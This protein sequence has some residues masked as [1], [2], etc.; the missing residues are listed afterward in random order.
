MGISSNA[1]RAGAAVLIGL[2]AP[3]RAWAQSTLVSVST[4][5]NFHTAGVLAT[6]SGDPQ[7]NAYC[8]LAY[9]R[10]ADA[11]FKPALSFP[12][13]DATHL[14]GSL[15]GL[16]PGTAYDVRVT[17]V[18]PDGV[19]G[20]ATQTTSVTTRADSF[21][22][23]SVQTLYV[24]TTGNDGNP[25][26]AALPLRTIGRAEA[27][28]APGT[29]VLIQPGV[30]REEVT[31]NVAG[32][33]AQP[34]VFRGNGLGAVLD[35]AD[36]AI[37]AG[38]PWTNE[39]GGVYARQTGFPTDHVVSERGRLYRYASPAALQA[40]GAGY[41]GGFHFDGTTLRVRFSDNTSPATHTMHVAR[42]EQGFHVTGGASFV[43]VENV[44]I[45]HYG[46]GGFGK[47][48]YLNRV[49]DSAVRACRIHEVESAGVWI[50]GGSRH[51]VEDNQIWDTNIFNWPWDLVKGSTAENNAVTFTDEAGQGHVLRRNT[52]Y[53][54]FNG[55]GPCGSVAIPQITT[56][57][58]VHHN[59]MS[60]HLDDALEPEG[61]CSNVRIF[62]N[63]IR[64]VHM[65]F[66][67]APANPGPTY[68]VRNVAYN[69]G[70]T[71]ASQVDGYLASA[72]KINSGFSEPVG[73]LF[74]LH[75]TF[76]TQAPLTSA[77]TLLNPGNSTSITARNN[78]FAGTDYALY[79][80]NPVALNWD[81]DDLHTTAASRLVRWHTGASYTTLG[82]FQS[83][84]GQEPTGLSAP[85]NL[86]NPAGG[87]Y[88]PATG[89][90]LINAGVP[91]GNINDDAIGAPDIGAIEVGAAPPPTTR[92]FTLPP[93]RLVDTRG[94][95]GPL[96]G[97]MIF[98]AAT[99][100]FPLTGTCGV[101]ATAK[102]LVLNATIVSPAA[103]GHIRLFP[104]NEAAPLAS[105]T[106]FVAGRNRAGIAIVRLATDGAGTV[107]LLNGSAG[108][109]HF[110]LD[111]TGY[112]E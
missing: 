52:T 88:Q 72:L 26:T 44:E 101:P 59:T 79:K 100:V 108:T 103:A 96:G 75:N 54:T 76:L 36:A 5:G 57:V 91:L 31:V 56:E 112:F 58:D 110:V 82:A 32:T 60:Q 3:A 23:P 51:V 102:A 16:T 8:T 11:A 38:V 41:P 97:P 64:D 109:L 37:A 25:G 61:H 27:L 49:N 30:Y 6:I 53:G 65:A 95:A 19:S 62:E 94:P 71:R 40:L 86:V 74:L 13:I 87:L 55:F 67:V 22:E 68:L 48:V 98:P 70:N 2:L 104:G 63:R 15:F 34:I 18:D 29:L 4:Y 66:A 46:S 24:A 39:G 28:A 107:G 42:F 92:Y 80:V 89:S 50:K 106:Q 1:W 93:C 10:S 81:R 21:P 9:K 47:G 35:G 83:G 12:K 77:M 99:R 84:T 33:A 85:P 7:G 105:L 90:A 78:V 20:N 17:L 14:A 111:V 73:P 69:F 43:R 45:R